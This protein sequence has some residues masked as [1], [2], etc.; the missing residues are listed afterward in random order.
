[1]TSV[2]PDAVSA[3]LGLVAVAG[4][5]TCLG[6]IVLLH[7]LPTGY[8]PVRNAVSDYGVGPYRI[9]HRI[10]VV[11]L[12]VAGFAMAIVSSGSTRPEPPSVIGFL[13][14]FSVA[15]VLI[16]FFPTDMLILL[17]LIML[18]FNEIKACFKIRP[19]LCPNHIRLFPM[20]SLWPRGLFDSLINRAS[21]HSRNH[22]F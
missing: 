4:A 8:D 5:A 19:Q 7:L 9:W 17:M 2:S 3:A 18:I 21:S 16:P 22:D 6:S 20:L 15:R 14:A 11:A 12:A 10:A 1:M 13:L